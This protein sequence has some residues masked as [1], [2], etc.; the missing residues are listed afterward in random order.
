MPLAIELAAARLRIL[1]CEQILSR[2][3]DRFSLL[4]DG[5][6]TA[7]P[8]HRTLRET[9]DWSYELLSE[10]E[11]AL[12]SRLAIFAGGWSLEAAEAVCDDNDDPAGSSIGRGE[13]LDL[14]S[15]LVDKSMV[16]T[17]KKEGERRYRLLETIRQYSL[18]KLRQ[19]KDEELLRNRHLAWYL[20]LAQ[21]AEPM[22]CRGEQIVWMNRIEVELDNLRAAMDWSVKVRKGEEAGRLASAPLLFWLARGRH[23]EGRQRLE[24]A[25]QVSVKSATAARAKALYAAC[26]IGYWFADFDRMLPCGRECHAIAEELGDESL[27]AWA[28]M[29][30]SIA[31]HNLEQAEK[32]IAHAQKSLNIFRRIGDRWGILNSLLC[33]GAILNTRSDI[34][35]SMPLLEEGLRLARDQG[36]RLH[37][38]WALNN[39]GRNYQLEGRNLQR[40]AA[41][42][43]ESIDVSVE[44]GNRQGVCGSLSLLARIFQRLGDFRRSRQCACE[45]LNI[46]RELGT[47]QA[48]CICL[49]CVAA[50]EA[51]LGNP[52]KAARLLGAACRTRERYVFV[53]TY[54]RRDFERIEADVRSAMTEKVFEIGWK[55]G[56]DMSMEEAIDFALS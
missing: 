17:E 9:I 5:K 1:S 33:L 11:K 31:E 52:A 47:E 43:R 10:K 32:A 37:I 56:R 44:L 19:A 40:A 28:L 27:L 22:L 15:K 55:A 51:N 50:A 54:N 34:S 38:G 36:E 29:G 12:L 24:R 49:T 4:T 42:V 21:K 41:L 39:L 7:L 25:L 30:E 8:R 6:R 18:E 53:P 45:A 46:V 3:G 16:Q 13:V 2:L 23:V 14:L 48:A 20:A 26:M 35:E